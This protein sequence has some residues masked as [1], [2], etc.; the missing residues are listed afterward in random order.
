MSGIK[1]S[2]RESESKLAKQTAGTAQPNPGTGEHGVV[3][4][5]RAQE[6]PKDKPRAQGEQT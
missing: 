2:A 1:P 4:D 3:L 6:Q 5:E